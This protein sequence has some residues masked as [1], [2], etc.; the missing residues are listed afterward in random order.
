MTGA[1][2]DFDVKD[3][4]V[5]ETFQRLIRL[6]ADTDAALEVVR[7]ELLIRHDERWDAGVDP[8]GHRWEPLS[9]RYQQQKEKKRPGKGILVYDEIL[10]NLASE[11][12]DDQVIIG[13]NRIYGATHQFGDE[14]RGIPARPFLGFS[15]EDIE[16]ASE[17]LGEHLTRILN[18]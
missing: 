18:T 5:G 11:V 4:S 8:Q 12:T 13:T 1:T 15:E 9:E 14:T 2:I 7:E 3:G 6:G 10:K 16:E 17:I